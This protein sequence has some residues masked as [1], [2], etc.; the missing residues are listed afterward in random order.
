MAYSMPPP[1]RPADIGSAGGYDYRCGDC[2]F[3]EIEVGDSK[4]ARD[5][6]QPAVCRVTQPSTH[7]ACPIEIVGVGRLRCCHEWH[8][9]A[10]ALRVGP[11]EIAFEAKNELVVPEL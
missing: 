1:N 3:V 9:K 4:P 6:K 5:E 7:M 8:G 10:G 11:T 2:A